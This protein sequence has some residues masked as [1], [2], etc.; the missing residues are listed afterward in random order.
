MMMMMKFHLDATTGK[1]VLRHALREDLE[2]E[3]GVLHELV[4]E[5]RLHL[6]RSQQCLQVAR[7]LLVDRL[8]LLRVGHEHELKHINKVVDGI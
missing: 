4:D 6:V 2:E 8:V 5:L 7:E 1:Q 3:A